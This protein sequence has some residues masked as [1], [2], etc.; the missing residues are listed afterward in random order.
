MKHACVIFES[1]NL[2]GYPEVADHDL[3]EGLGPGVFGR[4]QVEES[5]G[6][7]F[8]NSAVLDEVIS[9]RIEKEISAHGITHSLFFRDLINRWKKIAPESLFEVRRR[10]VF[11]KSELFG[12]GFP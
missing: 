4:V 7:P 5:G 6:R 11:F 12:A 8:D 10:G 3:I 2:L 1:G 9:L